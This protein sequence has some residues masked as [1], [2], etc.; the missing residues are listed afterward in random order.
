MKKIYCVE[1]W[2]SESEPVR[3][4]SCYDPFRLWSVG[5][6]SFIT[7]YE[8]EEEFKKSIVNRIDNCV[9]ITNIFIKEVPDNY[10]P[11]IKL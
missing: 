5:K 11:I 6:F 4:W 7:E 10:I 2:M 1:E 8:D 3:G 9:P